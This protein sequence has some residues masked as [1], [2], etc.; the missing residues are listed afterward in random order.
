[1]KSPSYAARCAVHDVLLPHAEMCAG[2]RVSAWRDP[3][4]RIG[5]NNYGRFTD[6]IH[7][8]GL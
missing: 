2:L 1:V 4:Q 6:E 7:L 8:Q 3:A 5:R